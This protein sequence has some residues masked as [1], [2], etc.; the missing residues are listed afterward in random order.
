VVVVH[1]DDRDA[2]AGAGGLRRDRRVVDEAEAAEVAAAGVVPRRPGQ[3]VGDAGPVAG[4]G[5]V[6]RRQRHVHGRTGGR[7]RS[8]DDGGGGVH[9][10]PARLADGGGRPARRPRA[11]GEGVGQQD[12]RSAGADPAGVPVPQPRDEVGVVH[13]EQRRVVVCDRRREVVTG[14]AQRGLE[15]VHPLRAFPARPD[16]PAERQLERRRVGRVVG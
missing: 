9:Q 13:G 7:P 15:H 5:P 11:V 6:E 3:P 8:G 1:V 10:P 16:H 2:T 14:V 4:H 12:V